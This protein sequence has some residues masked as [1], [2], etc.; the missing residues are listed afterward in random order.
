[1]KMFNKIRKMIISPMRNWSIKSVMSLE[2]SATTS[3]PN[4][5]FFLYPDN[6]LNSKINQL[7]SRTRNYQGKNREWRIRVQ[8]KR[9]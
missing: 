6:L 7:F 4:L 3:Y 9:F 8:E 1:M 5:D 2:Q